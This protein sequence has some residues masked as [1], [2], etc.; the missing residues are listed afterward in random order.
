MTIT[1]D[2]RIIL[3]EC[4]SCLSNFKNIKDKIE[5]NITQ[6]I[7]IKKFSKKNSVILT[8]IVLAVIKLF[9]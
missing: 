6:L 4:F 1:I 5:N 9:Q 8:V 2:E 3:D 7:K